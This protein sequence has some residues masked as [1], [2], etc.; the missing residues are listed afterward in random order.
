MN[1][2]C[3]TDA[4]GT[5]RKL[6]LSYGW[7]DDQPFVKRLYD[8]LYDRG[9]D[10]WM[11]VHNMPSRGRTLPQEVIDNLSACERVIA[12]IGP[13]WL[14]SLACQA[15]KEFAI[16]IGK[17]INPV[18]R[19]EKLT[20]EQLPADL[21]K[22]LVV[23]FRP[24]RKYKYE[25][26]LEELLRIIAQPAA[27]AGRLFG[28]P[29]LPANY[30]LRPADLQSVRDTME[31]KDLKPVAILSAKHNV[32][33]QGMSGVGKTVLATAY[34]FLHA[35]MKRDVPSRMA[36]PCLAERSPRAEPGEPHSSSRLSFARQS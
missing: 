35:T 16:G 28:V 9:Y 4:G 6:F 7:K 12:V 14:S 23:N 29:G 8:D 20:Y 32:A 30:Q 17:V 33:L 1:K 25:D 27:P 10:P 34:V 36:L 3:A 18:L 31:I 26:A 24:T 21:K 15:E 22:F 11:D 13:G 5:K 2:K 19:S